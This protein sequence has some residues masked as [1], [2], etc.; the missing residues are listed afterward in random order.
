[1]GMRDE[2]QRAEGAGVS[3]L[4]TH[5]LGPARL[6]VPRGVCCESKEPRGGSWDH[7]EQETG[8][9]TAVVRGV[10]AHGGPGFFLGDADALT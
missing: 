6:P 5:W 4:Q 1:M 3:P 9:R 2:G 10:I 7:V 8:R